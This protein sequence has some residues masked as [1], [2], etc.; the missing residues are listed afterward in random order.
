MR[1][2]TVWVLLIAVSFSIGHTTAESVPGIRDLFMSPAVTATPAPNAFRFRNGIRWGMNKE[3]VKALET[4]PM[5]EKI[6]QDWSV[7]LTNSKVTVS[8]FSA[9]LVFMFLE[10]KLLMISYEF[11]RGTPEDFLY[12]VGA[13]SSLY[14]EKA[15]ADPMKI[16]ALMDIIYPEYYDSEKITQAGGWN[17]ADGTSVYLY[18]YSPEAFAI[19]Y[20]CPELGS[21]I[22]QTNGL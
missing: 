16:K 19:M 12:L 8:R 4:E 13:L 18:Y 1:R 15:E 9:D 21:R 7:M 3:Q 2:L 5:T 22:Y 6:M 17:S 11:Q 14:G 10:D 20:V